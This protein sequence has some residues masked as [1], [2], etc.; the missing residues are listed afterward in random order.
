MH[1]FDTKDLN[2][3]E[4]RLSSSSKVARLSTLRYTDIDTTKYKERARLNAAVFEMETSTHVGWEYSD[5]FKTTSHKDTR[6]DIIQFKDGTF[7][8]GDIAAGDVNLNNIEWAYSGSHI[9]LKDGEDV[10][11]VATWREKYV[12]GSYCWSFLGVRADNTYILGAVDQNY[13]ISSHHLREYLKEQ[14]CI[15]AMVN[16]GGGSA[17]LI[18]DGKIT[19]RTTERAIANGLFLYEQIESDEV[20]EEENSEKIVELQNQLMIVT[21]ERDEWK[22]KCEKLETKCHDLEESMNVLQ[23]EH[24]KLKSIMDNIKALVGV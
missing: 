11:I 4:L 20:V 24:N 14:G 2:K 16:D 23:T 21:E 6:A 19:N 3:C 18:V 12:T 9:I 22:S 17:E 7:M 15:H 1:V 13:T 10:A 8:L 5:V